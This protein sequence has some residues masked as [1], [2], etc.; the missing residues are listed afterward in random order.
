MYYRGCWHMYLPRLL[1]QFKP[2]MM[3]GAQTLQLP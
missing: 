3:A 1:F 2:I